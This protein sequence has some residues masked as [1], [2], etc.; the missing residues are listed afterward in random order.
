MAGFDF[1]VSFGCRFGCARK[2]YLDAKVSKDWPNI[3]KNTE[4][5]HV[6]H[7]LAVQAG[8]F[9]TPMV[10]MEIVQNRIRMNGL[11][12]ADLN[13]SRG[14]GPLFKLLSGSR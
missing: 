6:L 2:G 9:P 3:P 11:I 1:M 8:S 12:K 5:G 4:T 7:T 14:S 10:L 13:S